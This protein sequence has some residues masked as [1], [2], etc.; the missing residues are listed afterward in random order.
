ME[1]PRHASSRVWNSTLYGRYQLS[2]DTRFVLVFPWVI[3]EPYRITINLIRPRTTI[4]L[5]G[6]SS[7]GLESTEEPPCRDQG[8][9]GS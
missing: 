4:H 2:R 7:P 1:C 5:P 8:A 3:L 9:S 6:P